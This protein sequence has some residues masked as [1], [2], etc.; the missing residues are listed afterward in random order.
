MKFT[1]FVR[2]LFGHRKGRT[3]CTSRRCRPVVEMLE[4]RLA[5]ALFA[6]AQNFAAGDDP[7]RMTVGD[8]NGDGI[9]DLA[10]VHSS[11][12]AFVNVLLGTGNGNFITA[13]G[14][15]FAVG[16]DARDLTSADFNGDGLSDLAVPI[17]SGAPGRG[18][19]IFLAT[20]GGQFAE[21]A[22]SP[23]GLPHYVES[24]AT[25]DFN[26][27]GKADL[28]VNSREGDHFTDTVSVLLGD[29]AGGF[30]GPLNLNVGS[31]PYSLAVADC[32]RDGKQ[33]VIVVN[34]FSNAIHVYLGDGAGGFGNAINSAVPLAPYRVGVGDFNH[35]GTPGTQDD[36]T[37]IL[38]G[39]GTG[40][41]TPAPGGASFVGGSNGIVVGDFN[42]D[43][44]LDFAAVGTFSGPALAFVYLGD[45]N[46]GFTP[47]S[48]NPFTVG[49][50]PRA[51][52]A[53]DF[54]RDGRLDF[55]TANGADDNV[56]ILLNTLPPDVHL[57]FASA[58]NFSAGDFP[59]FVATADFNR[60]GRD[61]LVV[62]NSNSNNVSIMLGNGSGGFQTAVN[63]GAGSG[64]VWVAVGDFNRDGKKDLAVANR[65]SGNVSILLG[66][67][68]GTFQAAVNYGAGNG[69]ISVAIGDFNADGRFDLVVA[70][71]NGGNVSILLGNGDGTFQTAVNYA[72]SFIPSSVAVG[73]FNADGKADLAVADG[74]S[75]VS[76]L[77]GNG[78]GTFQNAV[79]YPTAS[80]ATCVAIGD[81][82]ADGKPDLAVTAHDNSSVSILLGNGNGTFQTAVNYS[83]RPLPESIRVGDFNADGNLDLAVGT[84]SDVSILLGLGNGTFAT[85]IN[86][87]ASGQPYDLALGDFNRDGKTDI[88]TAN[89]GGN[90]VSLLLN[91]SRRQRRRQ[92]RQRPYPARS[93]SPR[94][95]CARRQ[96]DPVQP[97]R[98]RPHHHFVRR[99]AGHHR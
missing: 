55:A 62:A 32:N 78:N 37:Q 23:F 65:F 33:D 51:I 56:S 64:P 54:D 44:T 59:T 38:V 9:M 70:N 86:F 11:A 43:G 18:V 8:F 5:P 26:N 24:I 89:N 40:A 3:I 39:D 74:C 45:G 58:V 7:I 49:G 68:D 93:H 80:G 63:Y 52:V 81:F 19:R 6:P 73:D 61:D 46:L 88:V 27:D 96:H 95:R 85:A 31:A 21:A 75:N 99:R 17:Y 91:D 92:P 72:A 13:P 87:A 4:D 35:D 79:N 36:V 47:A 28:V 41:F 94:Q 2:V 66:N 1:T 10:T 98:R 67:G 82:N 15:P 14:S 48:G 34:S 22:G 77:L 25:A 20:G 16:F 76:V 12:S 71:T 53:A 83:V 42:G 29:G 90:N 60:D 69:P 30:G 50:N 57:S 84:V 97:R